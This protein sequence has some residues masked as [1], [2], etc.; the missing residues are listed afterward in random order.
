MG[1]ISCHNGPN[2]AGDVS[3]SNFKR[4]PTYKDFEYE[5]LYHLSDDLGRFNVTK[6]ESDKN[7]WRVPTLRN[8]ARTAPYFHNGSVGKL[9]DAVR[10][11]AKVQLDREL[12]DDQIDDI[13][14]FLNSL[15]REIPVQR[16]PLLPPFPEHM[17]R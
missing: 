3:S 5:R 15:T 6:I 12:Q 14:E 7:I 11:M 2:F 17:Y 13:V 4:F 16:M 1:C 9:S 8:I 10:I